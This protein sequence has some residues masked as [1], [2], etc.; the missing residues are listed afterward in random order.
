[1]T[2]TTSELRQLWA[3]PCTGPFARVTLFG[4]GMVSV[5]P[6]IVEATKALDACF[7]AHN[8]PTH[9]AETGAYNCRHI[10]GG[11]G[12]SLHAFGIAEDINWNENPYG[13]TLKTDMPAAMIAD[14]E[15]IRTKSGAQVWRWGGRY[16]GNKDAMHFEVVAS[17]AEIASGIVGAQTPSA[18]PFKLAM[19]N[20]VRA[21][22]KLPLATAQ[23]LTECVLRFQQDYN[24][25][26]K[27]KALTEDGI[28]GSATCAAIGDWVNLILATGH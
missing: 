7:R 4:G 12:Y 10:T 1:M 13:H 16:S 15:A 23:N 5:R 3:P 19:L 28:A 27:H 2:R 25:L 11:T 24:K 18:D 26:A 20:I 17:P 9:P 21:H 8:Y 6:S 14:I 22:A